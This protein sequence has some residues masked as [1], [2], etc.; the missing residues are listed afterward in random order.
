MEDWKERNNGTQCA[1]DRSGWGISLSDRERADRRRNQH[2]KV[3]PNMS[4]T[5]L[6]EMTYH[7]EGQHNDSKDG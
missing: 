5:N 2:R 3:F 1:I 6:K 4:L 7:L